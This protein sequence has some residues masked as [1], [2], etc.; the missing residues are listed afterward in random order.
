MTI[1]QKYYQEENKNLVHEQKDIEKW[2]QLTDSLGLKGQQGQKIDD[3]A[4]IPFTK[5]NTKMFNIIDTL[6]GRY[7][8]VE[9][10]NAETIPLEV[11]EMID[12]CKREGY[13]QK[14]EIK[15]DDEKPDPFLIGFVGYWKP[16]SGKGEETEYKTY[17]EAKDNGDENSSIYFY[18]TGKYLIAKWGDV[19]RT[20]EQLRDMAIERY[21]RFT[22][23]EK[24]KQIVELEADIKKLDDEA[25]LKF[26]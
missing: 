14:L 19:S 1:V 11:L 10:F 15:W 8:V 17:Q 20:F 23:A 9:K 18:D 3:K 25:I 21:K 5:I 26:G 24:Q 6:C 2:N 16:Y 7:E 4:P 13:F 22:L 12:L